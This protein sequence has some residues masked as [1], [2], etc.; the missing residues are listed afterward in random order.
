MR[1]DFSLIW[2]LI[3]YTGVGGLGQSP[4]PLLFRFLIRSEAAWGRHLFWEVKEGHRSFSLLCRNLVV[5]EIFTPTRVFIGKR[6]L[7]AGYLFSHGSLLG[8]ILA[9]RDPPCGRE[10]FLLWKEIFSTSKDSSS[11]HSFGLWWGI[12]CGIYC[13]LAFSVSSTHT[14]HGYHRKDGNRLE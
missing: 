5:W 3:T 7:I 6:Y 9:N 11:H 8:T 10:K 2:I 13:M 1:E 12:S 14:H 4:W